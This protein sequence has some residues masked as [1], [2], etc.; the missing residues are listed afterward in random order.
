MFE[1]LINGETHGIHVLTLLTKG[2]ERCRGI[3]SK[4]VEVENDLMGLHISAL[5]SGETSL[6]GVTS[7]GR[8]DG[9]CASP[10]TA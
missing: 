8:N 3:Q 6:R 5:N 2:R 4:G 1:L 10:E 9:H 7:A